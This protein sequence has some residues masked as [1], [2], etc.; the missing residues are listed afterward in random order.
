MNVAELGTK[1]LDNQII[2]PHNFKDKISNAQ[3]QGLPGHS[4]P[5]FTSL[6]F[7]AFLPDHSPFSSH[8]L[9]A[10]LPCYLPPTFTCYPFIA[11]LPGHP[12]SLFILLLPIFQA[13]P[14][15]LYTSHP[16][17]ARLS[18]HYPLH[19]SSSHCLSTRP[20]PPFTFHS[21]IAFLPVHSPFPFHPFIAFLPSHSFP[22]FSF[23]HCL[24]FRPLP[25][26]STSYSFIAF[27]LGTSPSL[28][29]SSFHCLSSRPLPSLHFISLPF[30]LYIHLRITHR[31]KQIIEY[32]NIS[33]NDL[34]IKDVYLLVVDNQNP[35]R[36]D[37]CWGEGG[38][39]HGKSTM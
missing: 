34:F 24:S 17:I 31:N 12:P 27:L 22:H 7:I 14:P 33:Q 35:K 38:V 15:P 30:F 13:T 23:F 8:P 6:P 32:K 16:F 4:P 29:F 25:P 1:K 20:L 21:F 2:R 18:D 39:V 11:L 10:F 37:L 28:H 9:I 3:F 19:L 5:P 26:P 36:M